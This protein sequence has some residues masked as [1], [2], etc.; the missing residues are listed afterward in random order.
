MSMKYGYHGTWSEF[1]PAIADEGLAPSE[2]WPGPSL[3]IA[4][5]DDIAAQF[6]EHV[7]RFPWPEDA[8]MEEDEEVPGGFY[9]DVEIDPDVIEI[10]ADPIWRIWV[11]LID[12]EGLV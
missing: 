8:D 11:R 10:L 9:A 2:A 6:G 12:W 5:D 1:L 7:L 3:F 4:V